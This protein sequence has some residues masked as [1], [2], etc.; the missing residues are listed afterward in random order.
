[1]NTCKAAGIMREGIDIGEVLAK[2]SGKLE[3]WR[4][5]MQEGFKNCDARKIGKPVVELRSRGYTKQQILDLV[6]TQYDQMDKS[7]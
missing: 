7:A 1:M 4:G 6:S 2:Q 3:Y 5:L